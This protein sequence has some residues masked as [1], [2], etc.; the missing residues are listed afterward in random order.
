[1]D[2]FYNNDKIVCRYNNHTTDI[3]KIPM[4]IQVKMYEKMEIA[5]LVL[6]VLN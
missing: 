6:Y 2:P 5:S 1:M 3:D 4:N